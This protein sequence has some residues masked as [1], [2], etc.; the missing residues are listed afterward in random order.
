MS[1]IVDL[2]TAVAFAASFVMG[3]L[4]FAAWVS[5]WFP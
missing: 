4:A 5:K 1:K 3:L 2:I